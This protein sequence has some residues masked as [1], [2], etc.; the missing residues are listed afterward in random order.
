[1]NDDFRNQVFETLNQKETNDLAEI[2]Q[3][4]DQVQWSEVAFDVIREILRNR[5][6]EIPKQN[7]PILEYIEED[8]Y[9]VSTS[10]E[11]F[12]EN[13]VVELSENNDID[14]LVNI[15]KNNSDPMLCLEA[16]MALTQL[17]DERGLNHLIAASRISDVEISSQARKI[18]AE[19]NHPEGNLALLSH[20]VSEN[21]SYT[22]E[23]IRFG[24]A[25][26]LAGYIGFI[27]IDTLFSVF[28]RLFSL[29]SFLHLILALVGGYYIFKFVVKN[30]VL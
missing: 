8:E 29:P 11:V 16:A 18:L 26:F 15:L 2:W 6:G 24:K 30:T 28:L 7:E 5:L 21:Q 23:K 14:G 10:D 25:S 20:Q 1:M 27:L 22:P 3:K 12:V 13:Q 19:V 17:G 4:N 9:E